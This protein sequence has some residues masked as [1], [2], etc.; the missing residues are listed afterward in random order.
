MK[1][2]H[3][4]HLKTISDYHR[5]LGLPAPVHPL[6]SVIHFEDI[7]ACIAAA[8]GPLSI[9]LGYY[10][11]ALKRNN[12]CKI[13]YGQQDFDF[14]EGMLSCMAPG[15]V[16]RIEKREDGGSINGGLLLLIHPDF[17]WHT[18]LAKT[19][20]SYDYFDYSV[21]EA[22]FLS[23]GE[24]E[25]MMSLLR[26]IEGE[27][28]TN[29][30]RFSQGIILA[31][32]ELLLSYADRAY[33]R[34]FLTRRKSN[35]QILSRL[36]DVLRTHLTEEALAK[37]GLPTVHAIAEALHLSPNYLSGLLKAVT[38]QNTQQLIHGKLMEKAKEKLSTTDLSV[39]EIAYE[40]G[41]EHPQSFNKL[42]KSKTALSPLQFRQTF[43]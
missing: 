20:K 42:F 40:L 12:H 2:N 37:N 15:Q 10:S 21:A 1:S 34:Q 5:V 31:Q 38:G 41:F 36:E 17:L 39:S 7:A 22:L 35:H 25:T 16:L 3:P 32:M 18:P 33:H 29:L 13:R 19:I 27:L 43:N 4:Q 6:V 11:I 23:P 8:A 30:D 9:M 26:N 24:E 14:N 28:R